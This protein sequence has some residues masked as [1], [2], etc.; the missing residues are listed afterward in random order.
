VKT[1]AY[2]DAVRVRPDR[3]AIL[4]E[5]IERA[6]QE[7]FRDLL[8]QTAEFG[9]GSIFRSWKTG[10]FGL[11]YCQTVKRFTTPFLTAG[12]SHESTLLC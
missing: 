3:S 5:W 4:D 6:I 12:S 8:K 2:F 11:F 1:T 10:I 9:A 7:P